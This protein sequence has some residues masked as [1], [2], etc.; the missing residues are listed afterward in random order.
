MPSSEAVSST[1]MKDSTLCTEVASTS[2]IKS[3]SVENQNA[4]QESVK[5]QKKSQKLEA[6][7]S[8]SENEKEK[9]KKKKAKLAKQCCFECKEVFSSSITFYNHVVNVQP[10]KQLLEDKTT[11]TSK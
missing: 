10:L 9:P 11:S 1:P 6:S 7:K 8:T 2:V 4:H 5:I 3:G